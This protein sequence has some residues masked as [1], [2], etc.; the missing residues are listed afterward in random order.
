[1][2]FVG[3]VSAHDQHIANEAQSTTVGRAHWAKNSH[4]K[5]VLAVLTGSQ[6]IRNVFWL[7]Q[8]QK[9]IFANNDLVVSV[10]VSTDT[11]PLSS[12]SQFIEFK[13]LL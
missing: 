12:V 9:S 5:R 10:D 11:Q 2:H 8:F 13:Q 3:H 1:M 4:T 7:S 6:M